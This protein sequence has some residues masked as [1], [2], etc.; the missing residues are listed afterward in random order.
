[1]ARSSGANA[2]DSN[3]REKHRIEMSL[4]V[5]NEN[6]KNKT[7]NMLLGKSRHSAAWKASDSPPGALL[8]LMWS[9]SR[10]TSE[11]QL[12][13]SHLCTNAWAADCTLGH[14]SNRPFSRRSLQSLLVRSVIWPLVASTRKACRRTLSLASLVRFRISCKWTSVYE[15][16]QC[17]PQSLK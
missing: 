9:N 16:F 11:L 8:A 1:M 3:I 13:L 6:I 10:R 12:S 4:Q 17:M 5:S 15:T 14:L 2:S 7:A